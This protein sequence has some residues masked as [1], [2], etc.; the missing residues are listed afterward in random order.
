LKK[1]ADLSAFFFQRLQVKKPEAE[2][3]GHEVS[4]IARYEEMPYWNLI[5]LKVDSI[6]ENQARIKLKV[7]DDLLN[8]NNILH[9]GVVS[10]LLDAVMGINLKLLIGEASYATV[11][12]TSQFIKAVRPDETIYAT[13]E[14]VQNGRSVACMEARLY[15]ESGEMISIGLGS[16][17]VSRARS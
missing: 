17:K 11:S 5:G 6:E 16:F 3:S 14:M 15:N 9:G 4:L 13:A 1:N 2:R 12:L 10:S 8:G 7:T